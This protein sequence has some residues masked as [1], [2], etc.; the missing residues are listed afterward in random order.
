MKTVEL[1]AALN[2]AQVVENLKNF[3]GVDAQG[4]AA[5]MT[6][7][8]LAAVAGGIMH[9]RTDFINSSSTDI[10]FE[11]RVKEIVDYFNVQRNDYQL[12]SGMLSTPN[13]VLQYRGYIYNNETS[14]NGTIEFINHYATITTFSIINGE[15]KK[16][17]YK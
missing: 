6:P 8:R 7:E 16:V 10:T 1:S 14:V 9:L 5:L 12:L 17:L 11:E 3:V 2:S 15:I 13:V 4:A